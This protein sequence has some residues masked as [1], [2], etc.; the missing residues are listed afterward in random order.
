MNADHARG[1]RD[2]L[3]TAGIDD[4]RSTRL[5]V[6]DP[7]QFSLLNGIDKDTRAALRAAMGIGSDKMPVQWASSAI[8][9]IVN[10]QRRA[11]ARGQA[12]TYLAWDRVSD[13]ADVKADQ[14]LLD[15]ARSE[16][17]EAKRNLETAV[18][19]A[20]QHVMY[21]D[22][23]EDSNSGDP[24]VEKTITFEHENQ[25]SLDGQTVW[26]ALVEASPTTGP[27]RSAT[28]DTSSICCPPPSTVSLDTM[29]IIDTLPPLNVLAH[30]PKD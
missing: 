11:V 5:V 25:T 22:M 27:A 16:K 28:R 29:T 12:V 1:P 18:K 4:A 10:T 3:E 15:T 6:L 8:Y 14:E 7:G 21:L 13:M 24:R 17:A 2:V 9:A 20:Y 19:R 30:Q 23:G 26:L